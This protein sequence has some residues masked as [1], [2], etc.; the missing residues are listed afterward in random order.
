MDSRQREL[1]ARLETLG[2]GALFVAA[3]AVLLLPGLPS[4]AWLTAA[5]V[6]MVGVSGVRVAA[7]LPVIW[8]T[9]V[10]GIGALVAG[11]AGMAGLASAAGPLALVAIGLVLI[12][13]TLSRTARIARFTSAQEKGR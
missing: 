5:G 10:V 9:V 2:W 8:T 4:G 11:I 6:V 12:G 3:G 7:G 13:A 1:E